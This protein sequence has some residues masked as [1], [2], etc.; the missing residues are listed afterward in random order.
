MSYRIR[1]DQY[2]SKNRFTI[3]MARSMRK[4]V[5]WLLC[6]AAL[7]VTSIIFHFESVRTRLLPGNPEVT[8]AAVTG[9]IADLKNGESVDAAVV[10]FC[11]EI[12]DNGNVS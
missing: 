5:V 2:S 3:G 7:V 6:V 10:A 9:L 12:I 1:Y 4:N 11:Q 8:E